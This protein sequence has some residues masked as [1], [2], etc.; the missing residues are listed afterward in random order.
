[1]DA[2]SAALLR[3]D[4]VFENN[5]YRGVTVP[6]V[7]VSTSKCSGKDCVSR[8]TAD[9]KRTVLDEVL[10]YENPDIEAR[11]CHDLGCTPAVA[12]GIFTDLKKFLW[13]A[14]QAPT[15]DIIPTP[16]IDEGWHCFILYTQDYADFCEKYFGQF[17]HHTAHRVGEP[18]SLRTEL[19][20]TIDAM[21]AHFGGKPS[22]N[23]DYVPY[24][25]VMLQAA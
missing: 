22:R 4:A 3:S 5:V 25:E 19:I 10:E 1:M 20:P 8:L 7:W 24:E 6:T 21:H 16:A 11:I 12:K 18:R 23:W 2:S 14:A 13:L 9:A 17:I 15:Q